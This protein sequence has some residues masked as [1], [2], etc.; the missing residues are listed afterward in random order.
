MRNIILIAP[1]AAGKGTQAA[2]I[3]EKYNLAYISTGDIL[4]ARAL[5]N[6]ELGNEINNLISNG[7]FVSNELIYK[8]IEEKI[9]SDECKD[10][11]ILDG[12][13]RN[14]EQAVEYDKIIS[15]YNLDIGSV[16]LLDVSREEVTKRIIGRRVCSECGANYNIN[17][18]SQK[19]KQDMVCDKCCGKLI[20]RSDD[21]EEAVIKRLNTYYEKTEPL[22]QYYKDKNVFYRV[23]GSKESDEVFKQIEK[24]IEG[25][26]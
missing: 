25:D 2:K 15:K 19:P 21:N 13:P 18:E 23:D 24:L 22:I 16:I 1:Q 6:D 17:Y 14:L 10:G 4:R 3:R 5:V 8:L 12:F 26:E 11:Y 9:T 7:Y 20:Q